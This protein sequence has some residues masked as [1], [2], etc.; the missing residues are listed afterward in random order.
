MILEESEVLDTYVN[1]K[2]GPLPSQINT[3]PHWC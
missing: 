1:I 2:Y 3:K